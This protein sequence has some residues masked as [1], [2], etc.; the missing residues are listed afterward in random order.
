MGQE[1]EAATRRLETEQA[2]AGEGKEKQQVEM[3]KLNK[4][5]ETTAE[6]L[7]MEPAKTLLVHQSN[8]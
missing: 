5:I 1:I 6:Q 7:E 8:D 3:A 4:N 2:R